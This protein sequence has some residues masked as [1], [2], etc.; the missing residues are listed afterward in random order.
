MSD[1]GREHVPSQ[2]GE[3]A[4]ATVWVVP[5]GTRSQGD[6]GTLT[7]SPTTLTVVS[8]RGGKSLDI[9]L[10]SIRKVKGVLGS[11]VIIIHHLEG[12]K[13]ALTALY[14]A[15]PPPL[16]PRKSDI[17]P[18]AIYREGAPLPFSSGAGVLA[19]RKAKFQGI[20]ALT[21]WNRLKKAE[22]K[23]WQTWIRSA[24]AAAEPRG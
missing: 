15:K 13:T 16:P 3:G 24:V 18:N 7:L 6:K 10:A 8:E 5:L 23:R 2:P 14:F 4:Q 19:R 20:S 12:A 9:T 21:G 1:G 17:D 22:V 11:P